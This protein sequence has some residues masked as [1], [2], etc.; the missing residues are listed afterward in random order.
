MKKNTQKKNKVSTETLKLS[1]YSNRKNNKSIKP[2]N[3]FK[4]NNNVVF[5]N[6][7]ILIKDITKNYKIN[8]EMDKAFHNKIKRI[9][10]TKLNLGNIST[11]KN[12]RINTEINNSNSNI[13]NNTISDFKLKISKNIYK[14]NKKIIEPSLKEKEI[15]PID[16]NKVTKNIIKNKNKKNRIGFGDSYEFNFTF[17]NYNNNFTQNDFYNNEL[18]NSNK[19]KNKNKIEN[20][21]NKTIIDYLIEHFN[22]MI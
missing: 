21:A 22:L 13:M 5:E 18:K 16:K 7:N 14:T 19:L 11:E 2:T 17:N 8:P 4:N 12:K 3:S 9:K 1:S 6:K 15:N 20:I 10:L